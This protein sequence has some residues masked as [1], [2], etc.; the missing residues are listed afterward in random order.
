M[1]AHLAASLNRI[2]DRLAT[3]RLHAVEIRKDVVTWVEVSASERAI[4]LLRSRTEPRSK[5]E[6]LLEEE[7]VARKGAVLVFEDFPCVITPPPQ[8]DTPIEEWEISHRPK[9]MGDDFECLLEERNPPHFAIWCRSGMLEHR[10]ECAPP[11]IDGAVTAQALLTQALNKPIPGAWCA[12]RVTAQSAYLWLVKDD[13]LHHGCRLLGGTEDMALLGQELDAALSSLQEEREAW[14]EAPFAL[15]TS[16]EERIPELLLQRKRQIIDFPWNPRF[17]NVSE[18][19]RFAAIAASM[20]WEQ[21]SWNN[22]DGAK[23]W[24]QRGTREA[25]KVFVALLLLVASFGVFTASLRFWN[26]QQSQQCHVIDQRL[27][28][29][30]KWL[31]ALDSAERAG[32]GSRNKASRS[33]AILSNC[34]TDNMWMASWKAADAPLRHEVE[35]YGSGEGDWNKWKQCVDASAGFAS[36]T[37][38]S[39]EVRKEAPLDS[40]IHLFVE[41]QEK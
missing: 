17:L 19:E 21:L 11:N 15:L 31:Q 29:E 4:K 35:I 9:L 28:T 14:Q 18:P 26:Q 7:R 30:K 1:F 22:W 25:A 12:L 34:L 32:A 41:A 8:H 39:T 38:R 3:P 16:D 20:P 36:I 6:R 10:S 33:I 27:T 40:R 24:V 5:L 23:H 13:I 2:V 37:P